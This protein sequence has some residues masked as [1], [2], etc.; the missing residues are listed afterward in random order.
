M[1]LVERIATWATTITAVLA[2]VGKFIWDWRKSSQE[3]EK[4]RQ[5]AAEKV[6]VFAQ[7][8]DHEAIDYALKLKDDI[9][10]ELRLDLAAIKTEMN[11]VRTE[12]LK[13]AEECA[14]LQVKASMLEAENASLRQEVCD[15]TDELDKA[16][17]HR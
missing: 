10:K 3:A 8:Q 9:T 14:G 5:D 4:A 7:R 6:R 15:L 2:V 11:R 16:R 17:G 12:N 13:R 1:D